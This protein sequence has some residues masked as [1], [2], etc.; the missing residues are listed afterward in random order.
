MQEGGGFGKRDAFGDDVFGGGKGVW[1]TRW[2]GEGMD[3]GGL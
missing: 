3:W 2:V 1:A